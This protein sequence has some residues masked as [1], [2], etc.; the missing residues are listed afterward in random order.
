MPG[1][2]RRPPRNRGEV[3]MRSLA[4][5]ACS[6]PA[7]ARVALLRSPIL[8]TAG[9]QIPQ[10]DRPVQPRTIPGE[11]RFRHSSDRLPKRTFLLG[12][13]CGHFYW[14]LTQLYMP[15]VTGWK[16]YDNSAESYRLIAEGGAGREP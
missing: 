6:R 5:L 3:L 15:V 4:P 13:K 8:P 12:P 10:A 11:S 9:R 2:S 1:R 16:V 7:G 14:G